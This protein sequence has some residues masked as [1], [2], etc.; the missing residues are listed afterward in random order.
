MLSTSAISLT[1]SAQVL[2]HIEARV[3]VH[4][5]DVY[6]ARSRNGAVGKLVV[7]ECHFTCVKSVWSL[8]CLRLCRAQHLQAATIWEGTPHVSLGTKS[9]PDPTTILNELQV[10]TFSESAKNECRM[11]NTRL[12]GFTRRI[13]SRAVVCLLARRR[14]AASTLLLARAVAV[15]NAPYNKPT[16]C[17]TRAFA[18]VY[19]AQK[20]YC[21]DEGQTYKLL[22]R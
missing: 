15:R 13:Y 10:S 7:V 4:W 14:A 22:A 19:F 18:T 9:P 17:I 20:L 16:S 5:L 3:V 11:R 12:N 8:F 6:L 2:S 21:N 1:R